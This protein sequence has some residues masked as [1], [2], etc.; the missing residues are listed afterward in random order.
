MIMLEFWKRF[1][2]LINKWEIISKKV[3]SITKRQRKLKIKKICRKSNNN[4]NNL[5]KRMSKKLGIRLGADKITITFY[6]IILLKFMLVKFKKRK[7]FFILSFNFFSQIYDLL[8]VL[9][10]QEEN[11]YKMTLEIFTEYAPYS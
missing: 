10:R 1:P 5:N 11:S 3:N 8:N 7:L 9:F 6:N 4:Y 2:S